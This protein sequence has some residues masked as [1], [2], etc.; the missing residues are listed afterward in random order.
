MLLPLALLALSAV[1]EDNFEPLVRRLIDVYAIA[2][3]NAADPVAPETAFYEGAI[4]G[5]LRRLDPHCTFFDPG[6]FEQLR[7]ME[8]STTK[9]FGSVVSIV[10]G[11]VIILQTLP[12]TPSARSGLA[13]GDEILSVNGVRLAGL[14]QEQL[15]GLLGASRQSPAR[16]EVLKPGN[17]R[18][19]E[20]V[21]TPEEM[22]SPSVE[23]A[24]LLRPGVGYLR[25]GSFD[26]QTGRQVKEA[27]EKLGGTALK[28]LVLDLRN[29][30]GG[31]MPPALETAALFLKPGQIVVSVRG[32][33]VEAS[34]I[35]V[36]DRTQP[37]TFP[38]AVLM[39]SRSASAS[40]IVAGALQDHR[41]GT[42]VGEPSFGKGLVQSVY[43]LSH[44]TG[45]ALTTA[46]YYTP[47]G[48]SIQRPLRGSQL[49]AQIATAPGGG[50]IQPDQVVFPDVPTPLRAVLDASGS[51]TSFATDYVRLHP[52]LTAQFEVAPSL[53]DDFQ[54]YLSQRNIRPGMN[55]WLRDLEWVRGR[56]KTEIFNQALGVEKGDE[57]E[58]QH[59][60]QILAALQKIGTA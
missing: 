37:Y 32:R 48:R 44:G 9:G 57:I 5:M 16:L 54:V 34:E 58:A 15:I 27:I 43:P 11:R 7:Q 33:K 41:R 21:L 49:E 52:G 17:A 36:P 4:P 8:R 55:D 35:K 25:V 47:S 51:F 12:D 53:V 56:L 3:Q 29:N 39:N 23:R 19:L 18:I 40:E 59:D 1:P 6:Q 10:P 22:Q 24:F 13:P 31:L 45:M 46:Y 26:S 20:F 14:D 2:E 50:G 38:V 60:P 30:P 42:V 28:G